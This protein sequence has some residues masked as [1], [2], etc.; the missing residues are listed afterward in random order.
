MK[1]ILCFGIFLAAMLA[2]CIAPD[3][4]TT[5]QTKYPWN[6]N[7]FTI[8]IS[9]TEFEGVYGINYLDEDTQQYE[10]FYEKS[11]AGQWKSNSRR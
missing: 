5:V 3:K 8:G 10:T 9:E 6:E 11:P 2:G 7:N 1:K 4:N